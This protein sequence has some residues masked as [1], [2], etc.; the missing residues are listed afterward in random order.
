MESPSQTAERNILYALFR[1]KEDK[2]RR[3][4]ISE[5]LLARKAKIPVKKLSRYLAQDYNLQTLFRD[6]RAAH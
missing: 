3:G 5:A 1:L 6:V 2:D 4:P